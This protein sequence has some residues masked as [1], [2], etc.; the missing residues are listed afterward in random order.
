MGICFVF[1]I[2]IV[3]CAVVA[4]NLVAIHKHIS[5]RRYLGGVPFGGIYH[6]GGQPL[7]IMKHRRHIFNLTYIK[8][9]QKT[10]TYT[11]IIKHITHIRN[12]ICVKSG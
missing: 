7:A 3:G 11:T 12:L 10:N 1:L 5:G 4:D 2:R 8:I 6:N 9:I